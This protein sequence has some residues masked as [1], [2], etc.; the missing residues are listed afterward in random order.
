MYAYAFVSLFPSSLVMDALFLDLPT[1]IMGLLD[2]RADSSISDPSF[3]T[4]VSHEDISKSPPDSDAGS[5]AVRQYV[6]ECI[7]KPLDLFL[8]EV[9]SGKDSRYIA[10]QE[11][12]IREFPTQDGTVG[13][14]ILESVKMRLSNETL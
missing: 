4:A 6:E 14:K 12:R 13:N 8:E 5:E 1:F 3:Y 9:R 10:R 7:Y 2:D 11:F